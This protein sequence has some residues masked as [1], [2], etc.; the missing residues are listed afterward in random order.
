M[1][2][3]LL[4]LGA[5]G[6]GAGFMYL[7]D[8]E[9][10]RR[11]RNQLRD[12]F[13]HGAHVSG[14]ELGRAARDLNNRAHGMAASVGHAF[15][16]THPDDELLESRVRSG[17]G[18]AVAHPR[19]IEID[20]RDGCVTLRGKS[21]SGEV[22]GLLAA[23]R[24]VSGVSEVKNELEIDDQPGNRDARRSG[25]NGVAWRPAN[26]L[27]AGMAAAGLVAYGVRRGGALGSAAKFAGL[28]MFARAASNRSLKSLVGLDGRCE[29]EVQKTVTIYAPVETVFRF[30][31]NYSNFPCFMSHL[32]EV[33]DLGG[34]RS[35]WVARG[36]GGLPVD[37]YARTIERV[38]ND[39]LAWESEPGS[40]IQNR[41]R[42]RFERQGDYGTRIS[43]HMM[44]KPPAGLLGHTVASILGVDPKHQIDEDMVRMKSLIEV[45]RTRAHHKTVTREEVE[46]ASA[47]SAG[48]RV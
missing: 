31:S 7:F 25:A 34:G 9:R 22:G 32:E 24:N 44:Y 13:A 3:A 11:R 28:G 27:L 18:R 35:R 42:V 39:A 5:A 47:L 16:S 23:V 15:R 2:A 40:A 29:V 10:G 43:L 4:G 37:W 21:L 30:W 14:R 41:G 36:P 20:A 12:Q 8:P 17:I 46:R 48:R 6:I 19:A 38:E 1:P 33:S 45:G 26:R